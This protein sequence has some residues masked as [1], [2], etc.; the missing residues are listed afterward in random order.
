MDIKDKEMHRVATTA[1][2][3]N[4]DGKFLITKRAMHKKH[5]PGKWKEKS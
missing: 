2:I 3:Y 4:K 5:F 1:I